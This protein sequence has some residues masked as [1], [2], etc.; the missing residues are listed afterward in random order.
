MK[1]LN[2]MVLL[3][4]IIIVCAIAT[5]LVPAGQYD[6]VLDPVTEREIVDPNTFHYV[7]Q[8]P[9]GLFPLFKSVTLGLQRASYVIFFLFIIGGMFQIMEATGAIHN[10]MTLVVKKMAGKEL[11]MI[12]VC[13]MVLGVVLPLLET[14]KSF[15]LLFLW[16]WPYVW[17]WDLILW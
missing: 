3:A 1:A 12:P 17:L 16:C 13:M 11:L 6:R 14:L 7:E 5:Y 15:W 9:V 10:G 4:I 8:N 2:P